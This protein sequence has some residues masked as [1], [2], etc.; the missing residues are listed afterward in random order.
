[1]ETAQPG[2]FRERLRVRSDTTA[3]KAGL[4]GE[5]VMTRT[6]QAMAVLGLFIVGVWGCSSNTST[7]EKTKQLENRL[8]KLESDLATTISSRDAFKARLGALEDQ[9]RAESERARLIEKERDDATAKFIAKSAEKDVA[10]A[11]YDELVKRL[12]TVLG[13]A[14]VAQSKVRESQVPATVTSRVK[15]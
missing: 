8:A 1:M 2:T 14:K 9:V 3:T 5:S 7:S 4:S 13:Q 10:V 6:H 15:E 12:E 11:H